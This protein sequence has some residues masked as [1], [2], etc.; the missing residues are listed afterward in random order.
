MTETEISTLL[1]N[2]HAQLI[3]DANGEQSLVVLPR[4]E[5][6]AMLEALE[7]VDDV[8]VANEVLQAVKEG[9]EQVHSLEEVLAELA[10]DEAA[11]DSSGGHE[12]PETGPIAGAPAS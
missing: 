9:R 6:E 10:S 8:R 7:D 4:V 2:L 1:N 12:G 3:R 11:T 5:F